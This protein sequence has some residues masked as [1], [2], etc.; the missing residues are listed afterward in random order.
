[1]RIVCFWVRR[2]MNP[3]TC[4][5]NLRLDRFALIQDR[6]LTSCIFADFS[7]NGMRAFC[8]C[9]ASDV[10]RAQ[11]EDECFHLRTAGRAPFTLRVYDLA[12]KILVC[13]LGPL[14]DC[15]S[16]PHLL[17]QNPDYAAWAIYVHPV[18]RKTL[19]ARWDGCASPR[20]AE[21]DEG[22]SFVRAYVLEGNG[23]SAAWNWLRFTADGSLLWAGGKSLL[24]WRL[25]D[26]KQVTARVSYIFI[27]IYRRMLLFM[28][29]ETRRYN[30]ILILMLVI[31]HRL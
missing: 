12:R 7:D 14:E 9:A 23:G 18:T 4:A 19:I 15:A 6:A 2:R 10:Q 25:L 27:Y 29:N 28:V 1:M 21:Y 3:T 24:C 17:L 11:T 30:H 26:G 13:E 8:L 31:P 16:F 22:L 20:V 5:H